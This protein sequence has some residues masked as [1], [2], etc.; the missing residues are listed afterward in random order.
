MFWYDYSQN[1]MKLL[2]TQPSFTHSWFDSTMFILF[3]SDFNPLH[4]G[5]QPFTCVLLPM[6]TLH[7]FN[8]NK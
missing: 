7:K 4:T 1:M 5:I 3:L 6:N 2:F 8:I